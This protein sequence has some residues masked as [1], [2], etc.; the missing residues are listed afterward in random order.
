MHIMHNHQLYIPKKPTIYFVCYHYPFDRSPSLQNLVND[1][2]SAY[3]VTVFGDHRFVKGLPKHISENTKISESRVVKNENKRQK[4]N[5]LINRLKHILP[6]QIIKLLT[7]EWNMLKAYFLYLPIFCDDLRKKSY[8]DITIVAEKGSLFA[9]LL[10]GKVPNIYYSLEVSPFI[11][12]PSILFKGLHIIEYLYIKIKNPYVISQ[13]ETRINLLQK[14]KDRQIII[15]VTSNGDM[16]P[17]KNYLRENLGIGHDKKILLMAGGLGEDQ[18]TLDILTQVKYWSD[19][20]VIVLHSASG[21][22]SNNVYFVA[23]QIENKGRI[24]LSKNC[25]TIG[26]AEELIYS[27]ADIGIVLYK[28][29][30]FN[31]RYTAFSSGK[32]AAFLRSGVPVIVPNYDEFNK[33]LNKYRFGE[34]SS[35][36]DIQKKI[37]DILN[38]YDKYE[39]AAYRAYNCI[40]KYSN[41]SGDVATVINK[42]I[43][44]I[45]C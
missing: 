3:T 4:N 2:I 43:L 12:E 42:K 9:A 5:L 22:Y 40:Y 1:L 13:S 10:S 14:N 28:D 7:E 11:E 15:P 44:H 27:S 38:S 24:F 8:S 37:N 26:E 32:L 30:G 39:N 18:L 41:Y 20:Y 36:A 45:C 23:N 33:L 35:I 19:H 16:L 31:Y 34:S 17:K 6:N 29:L 25:L 21:R